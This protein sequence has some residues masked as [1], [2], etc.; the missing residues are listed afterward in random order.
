LRWS[1]F[2]LFKKHTTPSFREELQWE[3]SRASRLFSLRMDFDVSSCNDRIISSIASLA[4]R[5]FCPQKASCFNHGTFFRKAIVSS[6]SQNFSIKR[7]IFPLL[8]ASD[9]CHMPGSANS[10][11]IWAIISSRLLDAQVAQA[12]GA[13]SLGLSAPSGFWVR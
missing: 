12:Y 5:R 2:S 11:I 9:V 7:G 13:I 10:S 1:I 4:A 6:S 3:A 8:H